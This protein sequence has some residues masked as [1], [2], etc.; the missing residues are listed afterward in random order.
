VVAA[1]LLG[2][3]GTW[4]ALHPT[5]A[6]VGPAPASTAT[7][8]RLL[9]PALLILAATQLSIGMVFGSVQTGTSVLAT[10]A[11]MPGLTG[12][13]H[14]LLGGGSGLAGLAVVAGP[15]SFP[16]ARRLRVCTAAL[17][18]LALPLLLVGSLTGL[19]FALLGL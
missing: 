10:Q 8:A 6:L 14:G 13:L 11:G 1:A 17:V 9:T 7:V 15:E 5:S 3:F 4:F 19:T 2:A 16:H 12:L 18:V